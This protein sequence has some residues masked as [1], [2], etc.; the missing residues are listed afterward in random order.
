[1]DLGLFI[2]TIIGGVFWSSADLTG[3]Q[4]FFYAGVTGVSFGAVPI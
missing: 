1:M 3:N 2:S 4:T